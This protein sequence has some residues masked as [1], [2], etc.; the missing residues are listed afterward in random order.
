[1]GLQHTFTKIGDWIRKMQHNSV[2]QDILTQSRALERLNSFLCEG[3]RAMREAQDVPE[4]IV[5]DLTILHRKWDFGDLS[6]LARRG[7]RQSGVHGQYFPDPDWPY[8]RSS[9]FFGHGH[10]MNGQTWNYR[11]EMTRDGAHGPLIAGISGTVKDGA[12]SIVMGLHD[13]V[14]KEYYADVDQR[15][16][17]YYVGTALAREEGDTEATNVKDPTNHR[18]ARVTKNRKG[19]GP[20]NATKALVTS[21]RTG[22]EVRVFR[23][24]RLA[25]IVPDRPPRGFRYDGLYVVKSY[26]LWKRE[27]QI[28]R[29]KLVR[30]Q[31]GQGP[32]RESNA[33]LE[34]GGTRKRKRSH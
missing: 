5:E 2:T 11:T 6:V 19:Q 10:L 23:S 17:I 30:L 13:E 26:K 28:Y 14:K 31:T 4:E 1:M 8:A 18:V 34:P 21:Y 27:R 22:R 15:D 9:D 16:T 7:L 33:P 3:S 32:L 12:R 20:T 24:F 29:F 25:E